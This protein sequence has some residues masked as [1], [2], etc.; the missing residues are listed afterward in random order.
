MTVI[1][2]KK[3][4][5]YAYGAK[6]SG[7]SDLTGYTCQMQLRASDDQSIALVDKP[8]IASGDTFPVLL[9]PAECSNLEIGKTYI[10][11][12]QISKTDYAREVFRTIEITEEHVY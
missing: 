4:D 1:R 12:A 6:I 8:I 2:V 10:M 3:G 5:S 11:A 9:T 7:V